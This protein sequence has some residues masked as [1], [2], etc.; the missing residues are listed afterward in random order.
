[1]RRLW[2]AAEV[3]ALRVFSSQENIGALA[4]RIPAHSS[5]AIHCKLRELGLR[6]LPTKRCGV[7]RGTR[8]WTEEELEYI[9]ANAGRP[10]KEIAA[11]LG[12]SRSAVTLIGHKRNL[13][14]S[15]RTYKHWTSGDD[16]RLMSLTEKHTIRET[17]ERMNRSWASVKSRMLHLKIR[18]LNGC[19]SLEEAARET[20]YD[21]YQLQRARAALGQTWRRCSTQYVISTE[22]LDALCNYLKEEKW[23]H[24]YDRAVNQRAS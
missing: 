9:R 4:S 7:P 13:W 3:Q 10:R 11:I 17:A 1:M 12:R 16:F 6:C 8:A 18:A 14:G 2:T 15:S 22:K 24:S 21:P 5:G 20:G 19:F 23:G